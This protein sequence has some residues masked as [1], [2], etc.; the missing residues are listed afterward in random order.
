MRRTVAFTK[1]ARNVFFHILTG[2]NLR[3]VHCYINPEQHGHTMLDTETI[4]EWLALF[5]PRSRETNVI[6]LG[7]EPTLHPG[8]PEAVRHARS[9]GYHSVT[10]DTNGYLFH[11]FLSKTSPSE[12]DFLSFSLDGATPKTNDAIR[13]PGSHA[14]C[15]EG[16][17]NAVALG[18]STS[19][20]CTV[21]SLNLH[22][23]PRMPA[24]LKDLGVARFF[25]QV[26][27]LRGKA[28]AKGAELQ[29]D[30]TDWQS[31]VPRVAAETA[32]LGIPATFP[33]VFLDLDEPFACG[34]LVAENYFIFP[35]GRVYRCPLCEDYPWHSLEI[36]EG[37][38]LP[39]E[40][41]TEMNFFSLN[42]PEGCVM[43]RLI[44]PRGETGP[45]GQAARIAC[46]LLKEKE[47]KGPWARKH[48]DSAPGM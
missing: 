40:G 12:V 29:V 34:G 2:C 24:L 22:E 19:L 1:N 26:I 7:G 8:L 37:R 47:E 23:L 48:G 27:G 5:A 25:I 35:N 38:L 6:F 44:Q 32:A 45:D 33:K 3:C 16:I 10:V 20:I 36:R 4:K 14:A 43:A 15:T 30:R 28:G 42:I 46:C 13:G 18:F 21:S 17:R 31:L 41:I 39:R 11:G 9:L